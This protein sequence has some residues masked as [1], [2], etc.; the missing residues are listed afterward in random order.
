MQLE[1]TGEPSTSN[2]IDRLATVLMDIGYM[3]VKSHIPPYLPSDCLKFRRSVE[4]KKLL[5]SKIRKASSSGQSIDNVDLK[6]K[7]HVSTSTDDLEVA[8]GGNLP[9]SS[10]PIAEESDPSA[11]YSPD[12]NI[13]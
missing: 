2:I 13:P 9:S 5:Q 1:V 8:Y 7:I 10:T 11:S 12:A 3:L 4:K 6:L